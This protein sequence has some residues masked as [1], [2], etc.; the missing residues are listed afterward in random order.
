ML[1]NY[2]FTLQRINEL[3]HQLVGGNYIYFEDLDEPAELVLYSA[4]HTDVRVRVSK[5][6]VVKGVAFDGFKITNLFDGKNVG[7]VVAGFGEYSRTGSEIVGTVQT[8]VKRGSGQL[9]KTQIINGETKI[10]DFNAERLFFSIENRTGSVLRLGG[11]DVFRTYIEIEA[12]AKY[13]DNF[14][15]VSEVWVSGSGKVSVASKYK[16]QQ[17]IFTPSAIEFNGDTVNFNSDTV[18]FY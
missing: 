2:S 16:T 15:P 6:S 10:L 8:E 13:S 5:G 11:V 18:V 14:A 12:G 4:Q 9:Y 17:K 1:D 3:H 7:L